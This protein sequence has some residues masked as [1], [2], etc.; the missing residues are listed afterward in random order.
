MQQYVTLAR[1]RFGRSVGCRSERATRGLEEI[2]VTATSAKQSVA[3]L[4]VSVSVLDERDLDATSV[5]HFE[6]ARAASA[7]LE[8]VG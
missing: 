6:E 4:P 7:E 8:L 2:I 5:Q 3:D 1:R